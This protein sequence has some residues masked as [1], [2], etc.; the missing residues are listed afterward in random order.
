VK[1]EPKHAVAPAPTSD[2]REFWQGCDEGRLLLRACLACGHIFYYPRLACPRCS[3]RQLDWLGASGRGVIHSHTTVFTSFY[4][5]D[6]ETDIPY[7]VLLVDL[8]EGPRMLSRLTGDD[9]RLRIGRGVQVE[10]VAIG[11]HRYPF[12]RLQAAA[13]D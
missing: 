9:N 2:S 6:W 4:G 3:S 8:I 7:T 12:F 13:D 5:P 1:H 11:G 10:F